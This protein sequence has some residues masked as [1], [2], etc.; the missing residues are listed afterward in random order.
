[1]KKLLIIALLLW[2]CGNE[3]TAVEE[4]ESPYILLEWISWSVST[5]YTTTDDCDIQF[6]DEQ[7]DDP[8]SCDEIRYY[9]DTNY[10][11]CINYKNYGFT[12]VETYCAEND[13]YYEE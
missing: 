2:G 9:T 5:C 13:C 10:F 11:H 3:I 7:D 1:M 6:D 12:K 4:E 8:T